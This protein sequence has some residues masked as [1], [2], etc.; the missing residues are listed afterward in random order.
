MRCREVPGTFLIGNGNMQ[1]INVILW[2]TIFLWGCSNI[3]TY[4]LFGEAA[5]IPSNLVFIG[6]LILVIIVSKISKKANKWL[7]TKI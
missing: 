1:R 7:G 5:I 2:T 4:L 3:G 6:F